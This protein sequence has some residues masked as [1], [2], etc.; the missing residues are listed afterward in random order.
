VQAVPIGGTGHDAVAEQRAGQSAHHGPSRRVVLVDQGPGAP[1]RGPAPAP[2]IAGPDERR[3]C[4]RSG[5]P[6]A[7][8]RAIGSRRNSSRVAE[9]WSVRKG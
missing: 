3:R 1:A 9:Q 4:R 7:C 2:P 8:R 6:P 5:R